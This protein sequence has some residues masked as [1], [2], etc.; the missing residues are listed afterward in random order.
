VKFTVSGTAT[1]GTD[2]NSLGTTVTIPAGA[3]TAVKTVIP[4][5]DT[6]VEP[7]ETIKV[8]LAPGTG[9]TVG[10]PSNATVILRSDDT[11]VTVAA[12]DATAT[13]ANLAN[14]GKFT[15]T[16]TGN[17]AGV[18]TVKFT[19]S[20]TATAG[21]DYNSLGT[22][23]AFAAGA[24]TAVK[25]VIPKQDTL[26]EANESVVLTLAA[27]TGYTVGTPKTA[28]V[29]LTSNDP[30]TQ[31]VTVAATD[32][33]ATEAGPTNGRFTFT[34]T[35]ATAAALS[36]PVT[37]AFT[38]SGTA[39]PGTDYNS[40]SPTVTIPA[41]LTTAVKTVIPKQDTAVEPN[42]TVIVTLSQSANYKVGSPK[43]ATVILASD[44][45]LASASPDE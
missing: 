20:G 11:R 28:T 10:S 13:E 31:T 30:V 7:N 36:A 32:A 18:L 3:T 44:D 21:T 26:Q 35:G 1:A 23:V 41:G 5:Q 14:T 39:T 43:T 42:E 16:R 19:V 37:V 38:V 15:F 17:T 12:T 6:L 2:Y 45:A 40:L 22:S 24:T 29:I 27:G 25:T 8:T 34:R 4:K 9:Y 33:T